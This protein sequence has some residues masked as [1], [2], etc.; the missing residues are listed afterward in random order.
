MARVWPGLRPGLIPLAWAVILHGFQRGFQHASFGRSLTGATFLSWRGD[1]VGF[2][3]AGVLTIVINSTCMEA[4]LRQTLIAWPHFRGP[5][6]E[7]ALLLT[8]PKPYS[9]CPGRR[10]YSGFVAQCERCKS[11]SDWMVTNMTVTTCCCNQCS[12]FYNAKFYLQSPDEFT[13]YPGP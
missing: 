11:E 12:Y 4:P 2:I 5:F 10:T 1:D 6:A 13:T 7:E 9:K 3:S 8:F